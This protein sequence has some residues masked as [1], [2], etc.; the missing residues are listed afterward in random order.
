MERPERAEKDDAQKVKLIF[1]SLAALVTIFLIW[2]LFAA[3][4]ARTERDLA[5]QEVE[6]LKQNIATIELL[7]SDQ[8]TAM[9][10]LKKKLQQ[11]EARPKP[12]PAAKTVKKKTAPA[13]STKKTTKRR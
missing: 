2:S 4:K 1:L 9:D 3:H 12:K 10:A 11:C 5:R 8:N 7:L 6:A 13:K